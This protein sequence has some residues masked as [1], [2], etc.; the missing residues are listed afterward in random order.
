MSVVVVTPPSPAIGRDLVDAHLRLEVGVAHED[1]AL[2][3]AYVA[4]AVAYIDGPRGRLGRAIWEQTL[5]LRQIGFGQ[6]IRLPYGPVRAVTSIK[7]VDQDGA[8]QTLAADQY[9]LSNDGVI[10]LAHNA[11]WPSLRG[12][13]EGVRI[14]YV[15]GYDALPDGIRAAL[16]MMV[17]HW[18]RNREAVTADQAAG[19]VPMGARALLAQYQS[20]AL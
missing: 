18:Y 10:S 14:R 7:Y 15:A 9:V 12:D 1:D 20:W 11:S 4:A 5:E 13:A 3:D 19:E 17:A 6:T 2:I 8:E 16:L